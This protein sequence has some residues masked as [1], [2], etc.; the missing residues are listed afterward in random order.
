MYYAAAMIFNL[1]VARLGDVYG[2]KWPVRV[3]S[4]I[5]VPVQAALIFWADL[6]TATALF[7]VMG[8]L[9]PGKV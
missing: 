3:S 4:L 5:S 7:F 1:L 6:D 9:S 8:A 2:R